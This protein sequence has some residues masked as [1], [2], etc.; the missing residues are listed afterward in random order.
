M[1]DEH[2]LCCM[3]DIRYVQCRLP[4]ISTKDDFYP[5]RA[6]ADAKNK[7]IKTVFGYVTRFPETTYKDLPAVMV[8]RV[9]SNA[10][11]KLHNNLHLWQED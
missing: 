10:L 6:N 2:P 3:S 11:G 5:C 1:D 9:H 4:D 8:D 7:F